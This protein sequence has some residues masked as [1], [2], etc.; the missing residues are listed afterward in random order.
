MLKDEKHEV[1]KKSFRAWIAPN[2][3]DPMSPYAITYDISIAAVYLIAFFTD[4]YI[5]C[6]DYQPLSMPSIA[7]EQK[8]ICVAS[9]INMLI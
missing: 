8:L 9:V 6:F 3:I 1:S 4:P 5:L 2:I 7:L